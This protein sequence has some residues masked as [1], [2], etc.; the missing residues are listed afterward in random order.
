MS[1]APLF[2]L[3]APYSGTTWLVARLG[4]HPELCALPELN[5]FMADRV[6]ELLEIAALDRGPQ[7]DGLLRAVAELEFREQSDRSIEAARIWLQDRADQ[8][9]AELFDALVALATPR[10]LVIPDAGSPMRPMDLRRLIR[11]CPQAALLHLVRH[12]WTQGCL[13]AAACEERLFVPPDYKD[14]AQRPPQLDPQIPWLR[15]NRNIDALLRAPATQW[16]RLRFEDFDADANA[17][18]LDLCT[19]L[20][21]DA[22]SESMAAMAQPQCWCF[23]GFGPRSAPYG[24]EAEAL[25]PPPDAVRALAD[26]PRLD[27]PLPWRGDG[28]GFADETRRLAAELGYPT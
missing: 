20:E 14:C 7:L 16:R 28:L 17:H 9:T 22:R 6:G 12:P 27:Q 11:A 21:L 26:A 13:L 8:T 4:M 15:A 1:A 5:L 23:A 3:A 19:W 2:V 18:L 25:E 10:R 24:L